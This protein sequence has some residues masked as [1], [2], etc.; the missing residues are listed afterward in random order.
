V[1][2]GPINRTLKPGRVDPGPAGGGAAGV[3]AG[4]MTAFILLCS[5]VKDCLRA[6]EAPVC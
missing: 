3:P 6:A 2:A 1:P 5:L 4:V